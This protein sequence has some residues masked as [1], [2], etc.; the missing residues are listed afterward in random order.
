MTLSKY[1]R[2]IPVWVLVII[3]ALSIV[4]VLGHAQTALYE[5]LTVGLSLRLIA[6]V[7]VGLLCLILYVKRTDPNEED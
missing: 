3:G 2:S 1:R 5:G 6:W 4:F 7:F